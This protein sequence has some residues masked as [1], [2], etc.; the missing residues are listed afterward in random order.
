[1]ANDSQDIFVVA[2]RHDGFW[3]NLKERNDV[4]LD[5]LHDIDAISQV[6]F[7][8]EDRY[9][10]LLANKKKGLVGFYL[11]KFEERNP[12]S[13]QNLTMWKTL[14]EIDD[15]TIMIQKG[16]GTNGEFKELIIG[17]KTININTYNI[18]V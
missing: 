1:V 12:G 7:H 14:L 11:I 18:F 5:E 6:I 17:Y 3:I 2:S 15:C 10:Y 8:S 16:T 9:F 13:Y 4:D